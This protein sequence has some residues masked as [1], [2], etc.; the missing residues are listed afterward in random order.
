[1][2]TF[3]PSVWQRRTDVHPPGGLVLFTGGR[4]PCFQAVKRYLPGRQSVKVTSR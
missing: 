1:M 4:L 2:Y 3:S